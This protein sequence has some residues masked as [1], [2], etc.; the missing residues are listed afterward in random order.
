[1]IYIYLKT[2]MKISLA[3]LTQVPSKI[4]CVLFISLFPALFVYLEYLI[5]LSRYSLIDITAFIYLDILLT[6]II[7]LV[8]PFVINAVVSDAIKKY[9]LF[10]MV[11]FFYHF[12]LVLLIYK[13][14]RR[15]DLD[16]TFLLYNSYSLLGYSSKLLLFN[17]LL[18]I[19]SIVI[20]AVS[21]YLLTLYQKS[22]PLFKSK[23]F[24]S[25]LFM[26]L[27]LSL[28]SP[29][30]YSNSL[31][32]FIKH[33]F[34]GAS[35]LRETYNSYFF[36]EIEKSF[37]RSYK[38][39]EPLFVGENVIILQLES[40]NSLLV[41]ERV[42][43]NLMKAKERGVFF[44]KHYASSVQTA[45][46]LE[47]ILCGIP[48]SITSTLVHILPA[49]VL[50]QMLC[51]PRIFNDLGYKTY[52]FQ[53]ADLEFD[54]IG[55]FADKVG[56]EEVIFD[57]IMLPGDPKLLWG[58]REDVYFTRMFDYL[59]TE[60]STKNKFIYI[61]VS[62]TNHYPFDAKD[63]RY[64]S[65]FPYENANNL[66][67]KISN[68]TF[69]QDVYLGNFLDQYFSEYHD[70]TTL[71]ILGDHSYPIGHNTPLNI[72]N[73]GF[74]YEEN[75]AVPMLYIPPKQFSENYNIGKV[76]QNRYSHKEIF[77]AI[78]SIL[79]QDEENMFSFYC[80]LVLPTCSHVTRNV[81]TVV[82]PFN[83]GFINIIDYPSKYVFG[84]R[85]VSLKLFDLEQDPDEK[86]PIDLEPRHF[87]YF[88]Q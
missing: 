76:V 41:N 50:S 24:L 83:G 35:T 52:Y 54:A 28:F 7:L 1:M 6:P 81:I 14:I 12:Y 8:I 40:L 46:S 27:A 19:V 64:D 21:L 16:L 60:S 71:V 84:V 11:S 34:L 55:T 15:V 72:S 31:S 37:E 3:F 78:V 80:E 5:L 79:G 48:P 33:N 23:K 39:E 53:A 68:T 29:L 36:A 59:L 44:P 65:S 77:Y 26:F 22:V 75:F 70:N 2:S 20:I 62:S 56:F 17:P 88:F 9:L 42:T 49:E 13:L 87:L 45:R 85:D 43:P 69:L 67:E 25:M 58:Y 30:A 66:Y 47:V 73:E 86:N 38:F 63:A 18:I 82:Q 32:E 10:T 4:I 51:L 57:E 74:A 61:T